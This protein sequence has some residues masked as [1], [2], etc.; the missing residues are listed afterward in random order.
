MN[1][2]EIYPNPVISDAKIQFDFIPQ[3][4][5]T[6]EICDMQGKII[7]TM[8][9][10][11]QKNKQ[12]ISMNFAKIPAGSYILHVSDTENKTTTHFIKK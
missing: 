7:K 9:V 4:P 11:I 3:S 5:I 10:P 8:Q 6:V 2:C 12:E 1:D